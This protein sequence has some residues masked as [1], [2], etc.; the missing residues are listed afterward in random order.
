MWPRPV[1]CRGRRGGVGVRVCADDGGG[2]AGAAVVPVCASSRG[3]NEAAERERGRLRAGAGSW[4]GE[5]RDCYAES[6][7]AFVRKG[8]WEVAAP[9]SAPKV[10]ARKKRQKNFGSCE[11]ESF[12]PIKYRNCNFFSVC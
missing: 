11:P 7:V 8:C 4:G 6:V 10:G 9:F 3:A 12:V 2:A 5:G 1:A